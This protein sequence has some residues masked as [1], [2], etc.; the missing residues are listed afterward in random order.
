MLFVGLTIGSL[1]FIGERLTVKN[2]SIEG[3]NVRA[4]E[5]LDKYIFRVE[6][7]VCLPIRQ[8]EEDEDEQ[9]NNGN[10]RV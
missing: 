8:N 2:I 4:W 10:D 3:K 5:W 6:R 1:A 7:V 9:S